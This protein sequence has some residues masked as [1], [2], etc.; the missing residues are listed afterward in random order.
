MKKFVR[1]SEF[2]YRIYRCL[3]YLCCKV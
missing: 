1:I 3:W 2:F